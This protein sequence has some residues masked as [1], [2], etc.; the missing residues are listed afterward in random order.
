VKVIRGEDPQGDRRDAELGAPFEDLIKLVGA[1]IVELSR[2]GDAERAAVA[3]VAVEDDADV[4]RHRPA[5]DLA[6]QPPGVEVIDET[7]HRR[8][9]NVAASAVFRASPPGL[10]RPRTIRQQ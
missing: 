7:E 1:D 4:A 8:Q 3:A 5:P 10:G 2:L 6:D 9:K